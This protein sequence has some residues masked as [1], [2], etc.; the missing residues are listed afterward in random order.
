MKI[1]LIEDDTALARIATASLTKKGGHEVV[2]ASDGA[3]GL[4]AAAA[5]APELILLDW[6]LPVMDGP[7]VLS[8]LKA[9]ERT[10][11]IPVI[12]LTGKDD[13]ED[14]AVAKE[15]G[16]LGRIPKPFDPM[17]LSLVVAEILAKS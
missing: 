7:E 17:T 4:S 1:L 2:V 11:A 12:L 10:R 6:F 8:Q 14:L 9:D 3:A 13:P 15:R 16:A 5:Q